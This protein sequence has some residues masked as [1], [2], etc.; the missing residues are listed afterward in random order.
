MIKQSELFASVIS[1][2]KHLAQQMLSNVT[3]TDA[4]AELATS[5]HIYNTFCLVKDTEPE[6]FALIAFGDESYEDAEFMRVRFAPFGQKNILATVLLQ[7]GETDRL[8][9]INREDLGG[10]DCDRILVE[11]SDWAL[12]F[13]GDG[14]LCVDLTAVDTWEDPGLAVE[15][16][17]DDKDEELEDNLPVLAP[18]LDLPKR[19]V[20]VQSAIVYDAYDLD[21]VITSAVAMTCLMQQGHVVKCHPAHTVENLADVD[22]VDYDHLVLLAGSHYTQTDKVK[23]ARLTVVDKQWKTTDDTQPVCLLFAL[24]QIEL[25]S[26]ADK[27]FDVWRASTMIEAFNSLDKLL[28][29]DVQIWLHSQWQHACASIAVKRPYCFVVPNHSAYLVQLDYLKA[30]IWSIARKS[31]VVNQNG[32]NEQV[33][34]VN[35]D[36]WLAPWAVR[37]ASLLHDTVLISHHTWQGPVW[38]GYSRSST[39]VYGVIT[40]LSNGKPKFTHGN[41]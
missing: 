5:V 35:V 27:L 26:Q 37:L 21:S 25:F 38:S 19:T 41:L 14:K 28:P 39:N 7:Q 32:Q 36:P 31:T 13:D 34:I 3:T 24:S 29:L 12:E 2:N 33:A 30:N 4:P 17:E 6:L 8:W 10:T 16:D 15:V 23:N 11:A 18:M 1:Q 20:A 40:K 22:A 9:V